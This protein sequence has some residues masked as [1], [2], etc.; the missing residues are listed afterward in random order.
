MDPAMLS[1]VKFIKSFLFHKCKNTLR[2][3]YKN[4]DHFLRDSMRHGNSTILSP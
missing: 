1:P 2:C 4:D 3:F